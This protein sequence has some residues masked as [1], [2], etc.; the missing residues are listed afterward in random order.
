MLFPGLDGNKNA[1]LSLNKLDKT[2]VLKAATD[3]EF[4]EFFAAY[5]H[6]TWSRFMYYIFERAITHKHGRVCFLDNLVAR[7]RRQMK[8][9]YQFLP[10]EE[11][12]SDRELA[13]VLQSFAN[14]SGYHIKLFK[15]DDVAL[16]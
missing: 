5:L 7:W 6:F 10:E 1:E 15:R 16:P 9:R 4:V 11:K 14:S 3:E 12:E 2:L 8:T 13:R